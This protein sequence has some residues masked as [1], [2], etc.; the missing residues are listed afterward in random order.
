MIMTLAHLSVQS[1][2][3]PFFSTWEMKG[4]YPDIFDDD[5]K[6]EAA[7]ELF[8]DAKKLLWQ[9]INDKSLTAKAVIGIL[10]GQLS[11]R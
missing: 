2:G 10:A 4:R 1:T 9:L 11:R 7:L 3:T 5:L 6:G 8:E